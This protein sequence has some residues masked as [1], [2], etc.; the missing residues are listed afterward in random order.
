M[1]NAI[2]H[3]IPMQSRIARGRFQKACRGARGLAA[4]PTGR[5]HESRISQGVDPAPFCS[6]RIV[7]AQELR[8]TKMA[9]RPLSEGLIVSPSNMLCRRAS[10]KAELDR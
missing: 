5:P 2:R 3:A 7:R 1:G 8:L 4:H 9:A 6:T 10:R